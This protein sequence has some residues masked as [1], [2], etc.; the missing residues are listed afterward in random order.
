MGHNIGLINVPMEGI[1]I[2]HKHSLF[3]LTVIVF[4]LI[5][6][7][8]VDDSIV[9]P[10]KVKAFD[11]N[12]LWTKSQSEAIQK[13]KTKDPDLKE[14][15]DLF[16]KI[17][18]QIRPDLEN[19]RQMPW[20]LETRSTRST[21]FNPRR[22]RIVLPKTIDVPRNFNNTQEVTNFILNVGFVEHK[23]SLTR[24]NLRHWIG[25]YGKVI[26]QPVMGGSIYTEP[27]HFLIDGRFE[28]IGNRW[29]DN[30]LIY[31]NLY[32]TWQSLIQ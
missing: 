9:L 32:G 1:L 25:T 5:L 13:Y 30:P 8:L 24:I 10:L 17:N 29:Y 7:C 22:W 20:D 4:F 28:P 6:V 14:E 16:I 18:G 15:T 31:R 11:F 2:F 3:L 27:N 12:D 23:E 21:I 26:V 19:F